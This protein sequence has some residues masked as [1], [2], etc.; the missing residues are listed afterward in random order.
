MAEP[1]A[2]TQQKHVTVLALDL[3]SLAVLGSKLDEVRQRLEAVIE[4]YGG[5]VMPRTEAPQPAASLLA[6]FGIPAVR[7][8][9]ARRAIRTALVL[10]TELLARHPTLPT[11]NQPRIGVH[12]G[13]I[14][15]E[16]LA[17]EQFLAQGD[18]L[19]I[20]QALCQAIPAGT[21][22]LTHAS[23]R[24][25]QS[26]FE[27]QPAERDLLPGYTPP[28]DT[29]RLQHERPRALRLTRSMSE[30]PT[31]F[32]GRDQAMA[33]LQ[34]AF[35][36]V[37]T[38]GTLQAVT[39]SG[40]PG[41]GKSRLLQE[42]N[43]WVEERP[44]TVR[45]FKGRASPQLRGQPYAL[46]RDLFTYRFGIQEDE[47]VVMARAK[48][49]QGIRKLMGVEGTERSHVLGQLLGFD[50]SSS[51]YLRGILD[52]AQQVRNR[53]FHY[54]ALFFKAVTS[55][56]SHALRLMPGPAQGEQ[57]LVL[58]LLE[59]IHWADE[60]SLDLIDYLIRECQDVPLLILN[61]ARPLLWE[62]RPQWGY[63]LPEVQHATLE[64]PPLSLTESQRVLANLLHPLEMIPNE[65]E[66]LLL[67]RTDG[68]PFY[69]EEVV[70]ML[71]EE[72]VIV[73]DE[74]GHPQE[75]DLSRL[76][77]GQVPPTLMGVL[78]ARLDAL[79]LQEREALQRAAIVGRIFWDQAVS[80]LFDGEAAQVSA[81][82]QKILMALQE[83]GLIIE[84]QKSAFK[85]TR[86]FVFR[87]SLMQEVAHES[88]LPRRRRQAHA[89]LARWLIERAGEQEERWAGEIGEHLELAGQT[90]EALPWYEK[91][92]QNATKRYAPAAT[93]TYYKKT[94][95]FMPEDDL[96][97]ERRMAL[98][99]GLGEML[100][101]Q[102]RYAEAAEA[103]QQ[104]EQCAIRLK[105]P[106]A[107]A[108]A[109][110][111]LSDVQTKQGHY[112]VAIESA[113]HAQG[114]IEPAGYQL[115][116]ALYQQGWA[117]MRLSNMEAAFTLGEQALAISTALK[118][119]DMMARSLKLLGSI[120]TTQG[121]AFAQAA[122]YFG[123]ALALARDLGDR[124]TEGLLLNNLGVLA[125]KQ[126]DYKQ[127]VQHYGAALAL[128][129][130]IGSRDLEGLALDNLGE[131]R[132]GLG[133]Y[134]GAESALRRAIRMAEAAGREEFAS[135]AHSYLAKAHLGQGRLEE[136]FAQAH[137]ALEL[138]QQTGAQAHIAAAWRALGMIS[139]QMR[140]GEVPSEFQP[141]ACFE[142]AQQL[143]ART[144]AEVERARTLR[145][146]ARYELEH[147]HP[148][149]G[150]V[151]W[152]DALD[153]FTHLGL[154]L[155]IQRMKQL[156]P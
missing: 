57:T 119:R 93:I 63:G 118:L 100:Q 150:R 83:Q 51:P 26:I 76:E 89:Q 136:A 103:Y 133:D 14:R 55:D 1:K 44:E 80:Q 21:I 117:Q 90:L 54:I 31:P 9:D 108:R 124:Q 116:N 154:E 6:I 78:Q 151:L 152:Q 95:A 102:S 107:Q 122:S 25:V 88:L 73:T 115:A 131:A 49:E 98:Y 86:E 45:F 16:E 140:V 11:N 34:A 144:G 123:E 20:A 28:L 56:R 75:V 143:F 5:A 81:Q 138:G 52:D 125:F 114:I 39:I 46:I 145:E 12:S 33:S 18:T 60:G 64:L 23:Y 47:R 92:G 139:A 82:L 65:L 106:V 132:V 77:A 104:V 37:V 15:F 148:D 40:E 142:S 149:E 129:E 74:S 3:A 41:V 99:Y 111:G 155:E 67:E 85:G 53:A 121:R 128:A 153:L 30:N 68:N 84:R 127:A 69:L 17:E 10:Q 61:Q 97:I 35:E 7:E 126:G 59:D 62:R 120:L 22:Y 94:L 110:S 96:Y 105:D 38:Q 43:Q 79:P 87:H 101:L 4:S 109:W 8:D 66:T 112:Q 137:R 50:F 70:K 48:L 29:Y 27:V 13:T 91:A 156:P 32:V 135:I 58:L 146:W 42:F 130:Q 71:V 113:R 141:R 36:R 24:L 72:E 2:G 19:E 134:E 147:G